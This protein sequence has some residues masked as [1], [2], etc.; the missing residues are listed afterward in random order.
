MVEEYLDTFKSVAHVGDGINDALALARAD[1]GIAMGVGGSAMAVEAADVALFSNN[2]ANLPFV[3][4]LARNA[5]WKLIGNLAFSAI[6]KLAVIILAG[7]GYVQLWQAVLADV[8]TSVIV[9]LNG[10]TLLRYRE[11]L[12]PA[13]EGHD[14]GEH[15]QGKSSC[16]E[17]LESRDKCSK[18]K[19]SCGEQNQ[20][21]DKCC[22]EKSS[23]GR[24]DQSHDK[25]AKRTSSCRKSHGCGSKKSSSDHPEDQ[26]DTA[27]KSGGKKC[28]PSKACGSSAP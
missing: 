11:D 27:Q 5:R 12:A 3:M 13:K 22:K 10:L 19:G 14:H 20:S 8:G 1:V 23:C 28:C 24:Q 15:T 7:M 9:T 2:L 17:K 21:R 16:G 18:G 6:T 26:R 25:H 4:G